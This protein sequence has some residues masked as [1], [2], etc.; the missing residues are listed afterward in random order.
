MRDVERLRELGALNSESRVLDFGCGAGRFAYGLINTSW[1]AG[2][3]L[4]L[5]V[6]PRH[7]EWCTNNITANYPS[8]RF[9]HVN[10]RNDRYNPGRKEDALL[11]V[12]TGSIDLFNAYSVLSHMNGV[13]VWAYLGEVARVLKPKGRAFTT[14][15]TEANV[16]D[17][18]ENPSWYGPFEWERPLHCV[19]YS[20]DRLEYMIGRSSLE[21]GPFFKGREVDG[22]T[23]LVLKPDY[24]TFLTGSIWHQAVTRPDEEHVSS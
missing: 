3:Y 22:Q 11:P 18:T 4:G 15:F 12:E 24:V 23:G 2:T 10:T 19:L 8:F 1:F 5:E 20:I 17:E 14:V 21:L 6:R 16:P 9:E 13:H 7:V